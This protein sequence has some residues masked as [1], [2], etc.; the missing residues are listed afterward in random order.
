MR[1][2]AFARAT[3]RGSRPSKTSNQ[4][5]KS[6]HFTAPTFESMMDRTGHGHGSFQN[7]NAASVLCGENNLLK[8]S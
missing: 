8:D 3:S 6:L 5:Q 2:S 1:V 7:P 4:V